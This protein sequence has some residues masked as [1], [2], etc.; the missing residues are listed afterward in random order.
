[1]NLIQARVQSYLDRCNREAPGMTDAVLDQAAKD[2]R[3]ALDRRFNKPPRDEFTL[4][5]SKVGKPT[6]QLQM[7][8]A[9][10]EREEKSYAFHMQMLI[11]DMIEVAGVAILKA[12]GVNVSN[13]QEK[14]ELHVAGERIMGRKD[15]DVDGEVFDIKSASPFAFENKFSRGFS[16]VKEGDTFGYVEQGYGYGHAS[17]KPFGGWIV[18]NKST[19]EWCV[20]EAPKDDWETRKAALTEIFKTVKT[21]TDEKPFERCYDDV[22]E[23]YYKKETGNR[24]LNSVCGFCDFKWSC[25]PELKQ[26]PDQNSTAANRKL[27]Y[28]TYIK[29]PED[30]S[31]S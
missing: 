1:M 17:N 5:L 27:K 8:A 26:K 14:V 11:G 24:V 18:I 31:E 15:L 22:P 28:Y 7:E 13:E 3:D 16:A 12:S 4:S 6:C 9:G 29:E 20:T 10:A 2:F 21:I 19:G 30:E 25:W 23:T